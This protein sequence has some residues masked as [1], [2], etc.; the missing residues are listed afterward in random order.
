MQDGL[1]H[2]V[3]QPHIRRVIR[4][5]HEVNKVVGVF[6]KVGVRH[7]ENGIVDLVAVSLYDL[8]GVRLFVDVSAR[9]RNSISVNTGGVVDGERQ[10]RRRIDSATQ[11]DGDRH[12]GVQ[13][14]AH[15]IVK[16][17]PQAGCGIIDRDVRG[18]NPFSWNM[19][20]LRLVEL[21]VDPNPPVGRTWKGTDFIVH[22]LVKNIANAPPCPIDDGLLANCQS[23]AV[24][25]V[26]E[27]LYL[28]RPVKPST[29]FGNI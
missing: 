13:A 17:S 24:G 28:R 7:C 11:L 26:D 14:Q 18:E 25:Q 15:G 2:T 10:N 5:S 27:A 22:R 12:I 29:A 8:P 3:V 19:P 9:K 6:Q 1:P 16:E 4:L 21:A 20:V 23:Q